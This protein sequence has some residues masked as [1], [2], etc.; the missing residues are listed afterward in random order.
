[1]KGI[2]GDK[3]KIANII[4]AI[5]Y[6]ELSINGHTYETFISNL[7]L[8]T[9][10]VKWLEIIGESAKHLTEE[11]KSKYYEIDW[12]NMIG[13]RN[14]LAHQYFKIKYAIVWDVATIFIKELK[15]KIDKIHI[16]LNNKN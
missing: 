11:T 12:E 6:I 13:L 15:P 3:A 1:M 7:L 9:S 10:V 2:I 5:G 14:I 8:K 4:E 16:D